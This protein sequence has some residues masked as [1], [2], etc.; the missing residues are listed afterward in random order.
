MLLPQGLICYQHAGL[1]F[2]EVYGGG[3]SISAAVRC[4][5]ALLLLRLTA[6]ECAAAAVASAAPAAVAALAAAVQNDTNY[7]RGCLHY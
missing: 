5:H 6:D 3:G 2:D 4:R 1:A 7:L